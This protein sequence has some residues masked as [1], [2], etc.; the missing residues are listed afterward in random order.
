[1]RGALIVALALAGC[2]HFE[3]NYVTALRVDAGASNA[4]VSLRD[5]WDGFDRAHQRGLNDADRVAWRK[6]V[7]PVV[8][9]AF[10]TARDAISMLHSGLVATDAAKRSD[11]SAGIGPASAAIGALVATLARF[12][13]KV[14]APKL[15]LLKIPEP[16]ADNEACREIVMPEPEAA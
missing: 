5:V 4:L 16:C 7:Q 14:A 9:K 13:C 15:V 10:A 11:W 1:M 2:A 12:G 6:D 8:D 3:P